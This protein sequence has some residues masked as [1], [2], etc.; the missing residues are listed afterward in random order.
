ML[1]EAWLLQDDPDQAATAP[2]TADTFQAPSHR[3][4]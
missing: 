2:T 4:G 3:A 1:A